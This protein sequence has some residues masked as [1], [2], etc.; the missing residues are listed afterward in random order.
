[1]GSRTRK[2]ASAMG[3]LL[4]ALALGG[5]FQPLYGERTLGGDPGLRQKLGAVE[6]QQIPAIKGSAEARLAVELRN[7]LLFELTGGGEAQTASHRLEIKMRTT[8]QA[9][10]V[11]I[12]TGRYEAMISGINAEYKMTEIGTGKVVLTGSTFSRASSDI[13]GQQQRFAQVRALR[14][15]EDRAA[16]VIAEQI[17]TRLASYFIAGA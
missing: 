16:K 8:R 17:R 14:D 11:D 6:V 7:A 2:L 13:P 12:T 3:G 15:A 1:M 10:I 9:V 4:L 5:C